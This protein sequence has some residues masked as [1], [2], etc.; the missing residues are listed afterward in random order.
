MSD[1]LDRPV[2]VRD[3]IAVLEAIRTANR[4]SGNSNARWDA[5]IGAGIGALAHGDVSQSRSSTN[6]DTPLPP[7][8]ESPP[9]PMS[10]SVR[11]VPADS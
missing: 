10:V 9:T 7:V 6:M 2:T 3:L 8:A 1:P 11:N 5:A 4:R